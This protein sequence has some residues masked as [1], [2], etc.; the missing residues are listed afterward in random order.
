[1]FASLGYRQDLSRLEAGKVQLSEDVF[2][3][4]QAASQAL[5]MVSARAM[6]RNLKLDLE[7]DDPQVRTALVKGDGS[8][9]VRFVEGAARC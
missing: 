9:E 2:S 1:V 8:F 6:E 3:P 7:V 5:H 4:W